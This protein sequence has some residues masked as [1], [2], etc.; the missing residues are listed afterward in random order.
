MISTELR[1]GRFGRLRTLQFP[2]TNLPLRGQERMHAALFLFP[3]GLLLVALVAFPL[4]YSVA[5]TVT[6]TPP[7]PGQLGRW[8]G[9]ANW[10]KAL[11]TLAP[12]FPF[13]A[14][15]DPV[16][17]QSFQQTLMY[18]V[19]SVVAALILGLVVALILDQ[20]FPGRRLVRVALLVPWAIPPVVV[21]AMFQWFLDS[22]RG[23]LG[24]W[25][26]QLGLVSSPPLFL[27]GIPNTLF[28]LAGIHVWKTFPLLAIMLLVAL[29]YLPSELVNAARLDGASFWDRLRFVVLPHLAP[30]LVAAAIVQFLITITMFDLIFALTAGGPGSNSTY[31]LYFYAFRQTFAL[32]NF[33][34]GAVVAYVVSALTVVFAVLVTRGRSRGLAT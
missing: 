13:V 34:Y 1:S 6:G 7:G 26:T 15:P 8:V 5:L 22:R 16:F 27:S 24:Y 2:L 31:N 25:I 23:L 14:T 20:E 33:N 28:V 9:L 11:P 32:N 3:T 4:A 21:A 10:A 18:V 29:Q 19:P 17:N 12:A 30:T